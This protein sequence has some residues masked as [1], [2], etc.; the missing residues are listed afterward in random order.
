[1]RRKGIVVVVSAMLLSS[2]SVAS[3]ASAVGEPSGPDATTARLSGITPSSA[4]FTSAQAKIELADDPGEQLYLIRFADPAV[5][6]FIRSESALVSEAYLEDGRLNSES[7]PVRA[8][9]AQLTDA[10]AD[11]VQVAADTIGRTPDVVFDYTYAVNG[12]AV[13]LN[14][15]EVRALSKTPG[16]VSI[17]PDKEREIHTDSGPTWINADAAWNAT[18]DLGLPEDY[19]GEGMVIGVI[20]TGISPA[21]ES[22]ADV[23]DDGFDHT[24]PL[25]ADTYLGVC[26][27][28]APVDQICN[29]KLIGIWDFLDEGD[30]G[31]DYDGHGSH[32]S[33]TA[34]GNFVDDVEISTGVTFDISG[35]APHANIISY[36]GCCSL[37]GLTGSIDQAIEDGVDAINYSIGS[38][39]PSAAWDDFD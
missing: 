30:E 10:H 28:L 16:I 3:A 8:Y 15:A 38:S 33:S 35:V 34:G 12:M 37:A 27:G 32:T 24:N 39:S 20:D 19:L 9:D 31:I 25:G 5:P 11:F 29:D 14:A 18:V 4:E 13:R 21:N 23:A 1:M 36:L 17:T 26:A 22:Y 6:E 7:A 2:V